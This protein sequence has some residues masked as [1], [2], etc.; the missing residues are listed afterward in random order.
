MLVEP[1]N[2]LATLEADE[3]LLGPLGRMH[4]F[5][6]YKSFDDT[7]AC[8]S[9]DTRTL[10]PNG[11]GR[12]LYDNLYSWFSADKNVTREGHTLYNYYRHF[13]PDTGCVRD[14]SHLHQL[15]HKYRTIANTLN[16][17]WCLDCVREDIETIGFPYFRLQHQ[18]PAMKRCHKHQVTLVSAC[19]SCGKEW[20]LLNKILLP[21]NGE[22]PHCGEPFN[23]EAEEYHPDYL[24]LEQK[25]LDLLSGALTPIPLPELIQRYRQWV[26][27]ETIHNRPTIKQC[28]ILREAQDFMENAFDDAL[29]KSVFNRRSDINPDKVVSSFRLFD[30]AYRPDLFVHPVIHL[31]FCKAIWGELPTIPVMEVSN[32]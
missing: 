31:L 10:N 32:G 29:F 6:G 2:M 28:K 12:P 18:V 7:A 4:L 3:H 19:H 14:D 27:I 25:S 9:D 1:A 17:R 13:I 20:N 8:I 22:C 21:P 23:I 15:P 24:W 30:A 5:S 26:G 11:L 16:W